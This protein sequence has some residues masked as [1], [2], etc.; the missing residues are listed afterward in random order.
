MEEYNPHELILVVVNSNENLY[1]RPV[2]FDS[3][4]DDPL[5]LLNSDGNYV[6]PTVIETT[7]PD[8][9]ALIN[10]EVKL[11]DPPFGIISLVCV[12]CNPEPKQF[13]DPFIN[14]LKDGIVTNADLDPDVISADKVEELSEES[15]VASRIK[16]KA[17]TKK[18][19]TKKKKIIKKKASRKPKKNSSS[20]TT[21]EPNDVV[22]IQEKP[23][24]SPED[25]S[26]DVTGVMD[27]DFVAEIGRV[28]PLEPA[29]GIG[30]EKEF[31]DDDLVD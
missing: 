19:T 29:E 5:T 23:K 1:A 31:D 7:C 2:A 18:K 26:E 21:S 28:V 11:A 27:V 30:Q 8:C 9:G 15:T 20:K 12:E 10:E 4:I 3:E 6:V 17:A 16:K 13:N 24:E 14:P 22:E 25:V